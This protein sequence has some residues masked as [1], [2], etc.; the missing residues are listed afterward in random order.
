MR[1]Q[2]VYR[3]MRVD[4]FLLEKEKTEKKKN[5]TEIKV[6]LTCSEGKKIPWDFF[7]T[8]TEE[9]GE[10]TVSAEAAAQHLHQSSEITKSGKTLSRENTSRWCAT[11]K[12]IGGFCDIKAKPLVINKSMGWAIILTTGFRFPHNKGYS[13]PEVTAKGLLCSEILHCF[14]TVINYLSNIFSSS[15]K[16]DTRLNLESNIVFKTKGLGWVY[17]KWFKYMSCII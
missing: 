7:L 10:K 8:Y 4:K 1:G 15:N 16:K 6:H 9:K 17:S 13:T 2:W 12:I 11:D 14:I 3:K 5:S